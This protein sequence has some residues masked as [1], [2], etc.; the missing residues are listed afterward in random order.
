MDPPPH[1]QMV[2]CKCVYNIKYNSNGSIYRFKARLVANGY[3][4]THGIDYDETF[5]VVANMTTGHVVLAVAAARG[6]HLHQMDVKNV[7]LQG[8]LEQQVF[9]VHPE[10]SVRVEQVGNMPTK[11]VQNQTSPRSV[12]SKIM[13][14]LHKI[15]FEASKSK[16]LLFIRIGQKGP[17]CILLYVDDLVIIDADLA[18][19][20]P[21]QVLVVGCI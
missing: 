18:E 20:R 1:R 10:I 14:W 9:M 3:V 12:H 11:E 16:S 2:G 15:G 6:S 7:F 8:D 17:I 13:Q 21:S 4:Q 19:I 5:L